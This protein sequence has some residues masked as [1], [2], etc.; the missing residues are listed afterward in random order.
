MKKYLPLALRLI[1]AIIVLQ[2]LPFKLTGHPDAVELFTQ[3]G[4]EPWGRYLT[5][6]LELIAGVLL[7]IPKTAVRGA[8]LVIML[9][10]G[11][12]GSHI[13]ILGFAG[14]M[15]ELAL[16]AIIALASSLLIVYTNKKQMFDTASTSAQTHE[17]TDF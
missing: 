15:G 17:H 12:L 16:L 13:M 9:M 1:P 3:L 2:T 10:L 7:L 4:V 14:D 5:A 6:I 11:A 8:Y